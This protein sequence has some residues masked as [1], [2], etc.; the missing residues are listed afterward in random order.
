M[1]RERIFTG[2][3]A[4]AAALALAVSAAGPVMA[5]EPTV[6]LQAGPD[7]GGVWQLT[8]HVVDPSGKPIGDKDVRFSVQEPFMGS[9]QSVPL[10]SVPTDSSGTATLRY[11]PTWNGHQVL[12]ASVSGSG[13]IDSSPVAIDV[14]DAIPALPAEPPSLAS[15]REVAGPVTVV[16]ALLVWALLAAI[17]LYAVL[18][19]ARSGEARERRQPAVAP[20]GERETSRPG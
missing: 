19:V 17:A 11:T 3:M 10:G 16:V 12:T 18:G 1:T 8:A 13:Q 9:Q 6:T 7:T 14:A 5:A 4:L 15:I 20:S 2:I